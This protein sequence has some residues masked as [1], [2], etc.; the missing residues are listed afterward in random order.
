MSTG[1]KPV[2]MVGWKSEYLAVIGTAPIVIPGSKQGVYWLVRCSFCGESR[3]LPGTMLRA[4]KFRSCGCSKFSQNASLAL[5]HGMSNNPEYGAWRAMRARCSNPKLKCY[6]NY[7][8]RG[9]QVCAEWAESF[10]AFYRHIGPRPSPRHSLDRI[11]NSRGYEPGNVRW[12]LP[13]Q[14]NRNSRRNLLVEY[15]GRTLTLIEWAE[16]TGIN[17]YTI[18][19]RIY[20]LGWSVE[21]ALTERARRG[22]N[23]YCV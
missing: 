11:D 4:G 21:R 20:D 5:R 23:G 19:S 14:Q 18:M 13:M 6:H 12:A 3:E 15:G 7:G 22:K 17:Y 9:I 8:G 16:L 10:E 2:D 1:R